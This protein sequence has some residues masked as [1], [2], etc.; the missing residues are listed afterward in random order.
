MFAVASVAMLEQHTKS[1]KQEEIVYTLFWFSF[2]FGFTFWDTAQ[3]HSQQTRH[4]ARL[5]VVAVILIQPTN[6][7]RGAFGC[8]C[9]RALKCATWR[10]YCCQCGCCNISNFR[11]KI[12]LYTVCFG[13]SFAFGFCFWDTAQTLVHRHVCRSC[14]S[15]TA[16]VARLLFVIVVVAH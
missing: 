6:A 13:F 1:Q 11:N 8:C 5:S 14:Y 7:P 10:V 3:T 12:K 2:A 16:N 4:V 9:C 15:H